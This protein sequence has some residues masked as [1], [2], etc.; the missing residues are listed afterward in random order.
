MYN[1]SQYGNQANVTLDQF[2]GLPNNW[3]WAP[4]YSYF[5]TVTNL[6]SAPE[7]FSATTTV[8][9]D[10]TPFVFIAP[11]NVNA[12]RPNP[13]IQ[14][15]WGVTNQGPAAASGSWY[16]SVW[17]STNGLLDASSVVIGNFW[18]N[19]TVPVNGTYWQTNSLA[20]PMNASGDYTLFVQVDASHSIYESKLSDKASAGVSGFLTLSPPDLRP[21]SVVAPAIVFY[22]QTN[23]VVPISWN[24]TNQGVG[25]AVGGWYDRVWF[26]TNGVLD[27]SSVALS[28]V[29]INQAVAPQTAYS[30][31]GFF[32][33][34][35]N[36]PGLYTLFVQS[37]IYN[38]VYESDE[39]NNVSSPT[40]LRSILPLSFN[41]SPGSMRW[42]S[43]GLQLQVDG[44]AGSGLVIYAST[45][46]AS[47]TPIYTNAAATGSIQFIDPGAT[48]FSRRFYR[49][50]EQ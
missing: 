12:M 28:D 2:F 8:P 14:L 46:L 27:A 23:P 33:L 4:G 10:L 6:S 1:N 49:A 37:D 44:L 19:Q 31:T 32:T 13:Q 29:Y 40:A 45:N 26:S 16:D 50:V 21:V 25:A 30:Q 20:L 22:Y 42:L 24:V 35:L 47:W 5:I 38:W 41:S 39:D 17:F 11:T 3:P 9:A 36:G 43:N 18:V 15:M 34:P 7:N 48:N